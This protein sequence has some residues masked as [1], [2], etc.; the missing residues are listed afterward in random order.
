[1]FCG[2]SDTKF[3]F[4]GRDR[5]FSIEGSYNVFRCAACDLLFLNPQPSPEQLARHYPANYYAF[6]GK[7]AEDRHHE[8]LHAN[9]YGPQSSAFRRLVLSPYRPLLRSL[10]GARGGRLLDVGCGSG[11]FLASARKIL[12]V[13]A[14]GVEPYTYDA[15]FAEGNGLSIF[16]GTLEEA[17]F[18]DNFFDAI[19]MNHVFEHLRHPRSTLRELQRIIK[20][21]GEVIIGV[22]QS[23][24][25][26]FWVFGRR[27]WQ[28]DI[29][30]HLFVPCA[31][32]LK[33]LA[34]E[35]GFAVRRVR[36]N[37][38]PES[39]L[40]SLNYWRRDLFRRSGADESKPSRASFV[41]L[42]PVAYLLNLLRI[43]DQ[44]E[45]TLA[46]RTQ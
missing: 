29:P 45:M 28:L 27:W 42:L 11:H 41:A 31:R 8:R 10:P 33:A 24:S 23:R 4:R 43:G 19:T 21:G 15:A 36:Y 9:L 17:Q 2:G 13:D 35:A 7:R 44:I 22:P 20:P 37:S 40:A 38:T 12:G 34:E 26:L 5:R 32:N 1:M 46:P 6:Q 30:R 3:C 14:Y 18:P 25:L 39:I 16:S